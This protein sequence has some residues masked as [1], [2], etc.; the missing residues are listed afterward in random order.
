ML[1]RSTYFLIKVS[2]ALFRCITFLIKGYIYH[3]KEVSPFL[4]KCTSSMTKEY[5]HSKSDVFFSEP[6]QLLIPLKILN[7]PYLLIFYL[8]N[9][10]ILFL[11]SK[12]LKKMDFLENSSRNSVTIK[13][14]FANRQNTARTVLSNIGRIRKAFERNSPYQMMSFS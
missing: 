3:Y 14:S 11:C 9:S 7:T 13:I 1:G 10:F 2:H 4:S 8:S 6:I 5:C 12:I